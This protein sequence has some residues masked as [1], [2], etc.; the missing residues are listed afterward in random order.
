[1]VIELRPY[2]QNLYVTTYDKLFNQQIKRLCVALPTGGGKSILIA[3]L[4]Q[5]LPG[6]TLILTHRIEILQQNSEWL[7]GAC[8]LTAKE[9][10]LKYDGDIVIAMVQT[11]F[12]RI[13][14]YGTSY[15][16]EFDNIILDEVQ[17]LIFEKVFEQYDFKRLIG[18]TGTPVLNKKLYSTIDDIE[19]VEQYTL[20]EIF[21]DIA[22]G[23][24]TQELI[25]LGYLVQ[26]YNIVLNLPDFDK[27]KESESHPDGYT[28]NSLNSVYGNSASLKILR[29]AV[30]EHAQ[31]KKTL[32]FNAS[33][34][35]NKKVYD[36]FIKLGLNV[37]L[38]D[39]V[40]E[41]DINP[42]T[43]KPYTRTEI[44]NWF[45][46]ERDAIL[47]NT[48]V[49]T[50]GFDVDDVEVVIINRATKS[51]SL[52]IQMVG[53][54]SRPTNKIF[55]DKFTVID[56]GQN[57][58]EH[59]IWS[60]KR[61]WRDYFFKQAPKRKHKADLLDTWECGSC[62]AYNL[63]GD[64]ICASCGATKENAVIKEGRQKKLKDGQLQAIGELPLPKSKAIIKYC[65]EIGEGSNFAFLLTERK[66][67]D[68]FIHYNVSAEFFKANEKRF[69]DRLI[70]IYR[71]IYF[72]IIRSDLPGAR[73]R[74]TT[75]LNRVLTK[76][77]KLYGFKDK[78]QNEHKNC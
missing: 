15:L 56:L 44:I 36:D 1:M 55:K 4:A 13:K 72:G 14:K 29:K 34:A 42:S 57:I 35:I 21:D 49:F 66:I 64:L 8:I 41:A 23:M 45:R 77:Y 62:G 5:D 76:I 9:N 74:L 26:D 3:K 38:F 16:G 63:T 51:L 30:K 25:D 68:L 2:Q 53:R 17:V 22:E 12:A 78:Q 39:T 19:Y 69:A 24:D 10:S 67:V 47:I 65:K 43:E 32:I 73:K 54:G 61:K 31:G 27:L 71:P 59:G 20:S 75:Q 28:M 6:R 58:H 37:K 46:S 48:N 18:F 11:A 50:T 7:R 60:M 40:N 52:W 33:T 70:Q